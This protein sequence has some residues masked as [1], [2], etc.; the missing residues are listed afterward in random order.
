MKKSPVGV[1]RCVGRQCG[2]ERGTKEG[3]NDPPSYTAE[4][5][6]HSDSPWLINYS[7]VVSG[8]HVNVDHAPQS[9]I[10][11]SSPLT[12]TQELVNTGRALHPFSCCGARDVGAGGASATVTSAMTTSPSFSC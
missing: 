9:T 4:Y 3:G 1:V 12:T 11:Q 8:I 6:Q 10:S 2:R 7:L 5:K